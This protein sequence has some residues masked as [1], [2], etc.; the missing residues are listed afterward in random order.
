MFISSLY[1]II[2]M[3]TESSLQNIFLHNLMFLYSFPALR[4]CVE[5]LVTLK[6]LI[7]YVRCFSP[8]EAF[9]I[10]LE[11]WHSKIDDGTHDLHFFFFIYLFWYLVGPYNSDA[12]ALSW[13]SLIVGK[14]SACKAGDPCSIPGL[15]RS[16]GEGNSYPLQYSGLE[17]LR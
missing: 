17:N 16:L 3:G 4:V 6:C 2:W 8:L 9:R 12:H 5:D 11:Y 1:I 7:H 14:E 13:A 10:C 15:G